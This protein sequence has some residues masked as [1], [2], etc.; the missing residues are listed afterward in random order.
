VRLARDRVA[1]RATGSDACSTP[2]RHRRR[3]LPRGGFIAK[4]KSPRSLLSKFLAKVLA[5]LARVELW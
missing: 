3:S 1:R 4:M 2:G 5:K